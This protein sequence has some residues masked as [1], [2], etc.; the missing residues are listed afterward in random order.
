[1]HLGYLMLTILWSLSKSQN[2]LNLL[3]YIVI[4]SSS[5]DI[6]ESHFMSKDNF[7]LG[8]ISNCVISKMHEM[9]NSIT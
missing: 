2:S 9:I 7:S 3:K 8:I 6:G 5:S 4:F 1:M